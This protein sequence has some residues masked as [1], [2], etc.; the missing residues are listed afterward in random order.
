MCSR[1]ISTLIDNYQLDTDLVSES[2]NSLGMDDNHAIVDSN[3]VDDNTEE[4]GL[5]MGNH[6]ARSEEFGC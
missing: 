4:K 5:W 1:S 2:S 6:I 3:I